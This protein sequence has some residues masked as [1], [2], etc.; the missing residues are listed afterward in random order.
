MQLL[1]ELTDAAI[2]VV[3]INGA[4]LAQAIEADPRRVREWTAASAAAD[5]V[6]DFVG[7]ASSLD[8]AARAVRSGGT[9]VVVGSEHGPQG[10][11]VALGP[12]V[13]VV[14]SIWGSLPKL[15]ELVAL[16]RAGR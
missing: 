2:E 5:V 7:S 16:A 4:R 10:M 8:L 12:E 11:V 3:E 13:T 15:I 14:H 6:L 9:V 1:R